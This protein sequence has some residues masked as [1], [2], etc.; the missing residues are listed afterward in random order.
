[1]DRPYADGQ[2]DDVIYLTGIEVEHTPAHGLLTLFVVGPQDPMEVATKAKDADVKHIY[3]G[4]NKSFDHNP[5]WKDLVDLLLHEGYWVTLDY[6]VRLHSSVMRQMAN[7]MRSSRFIP[8]ISVEI[9]NI[10]LYNYNATVKI[11]DVSMD[12]SNPGVW[13]HPLH[14]LM[15][16]KKFTPWDKY[17]DDEKVD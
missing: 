12:Y 13:C 8:M 10:E 15:S 4:A 11:D 14:D 3:L 1:M 2:A 9:P 16:R 6:P 17:T 7:H 5:K